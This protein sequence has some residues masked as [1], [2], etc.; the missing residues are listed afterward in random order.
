M[1]GVAGLAQ[2]WEM[3]YSYLALAEYLNIYFS[4]SSETLQ[5]RHC[6][7]TSPQSSPDGVR[8]Y[9]D[10]TKTYHGSELLCKQK[11]ML[12]IIYSPLL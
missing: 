12:R 11:L 6:M 10:V 4:P 9:G 2:G 5:I 8:L 7:F 3:H 1:K